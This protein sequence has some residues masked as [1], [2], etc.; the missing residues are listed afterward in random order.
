MYMKRL[1]LL[2]M[3]LLLP[4]SVL[5]ADNGKNAAVSVLD[6]A[7]QVMKSDA[8]VSMEF[9]YTVSDAD[10]DALFNDK[11]YFCLDKNSDANLCSEYKWENGKLTKVGEYTVNTAA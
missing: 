4:A 2:L 11:G 7:V 9:T 5:F 3:L 6:K 1:Q 8:G 10:G